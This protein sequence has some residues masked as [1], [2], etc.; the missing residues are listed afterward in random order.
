MA[1]PQ[2]PV[3]HLARGLEGLLRAGADALVVWQERG[4][5]DGGELGSF[6]QLAAELSRLFGGRNGALLET[7]RRE[8]R[9][10]VRR[11]AARAD[12][13]PAAQ[14]IHDLFAMLLEIVEEDSG[15]REARAT[16]RPPTRK[17]AR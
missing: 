2:T 9:S 14:R 10:E 11:W 8:L 17:A 3:E 1:E 13:D 7:L 6:E 4:A 5:A 15:A 16:R 12:D